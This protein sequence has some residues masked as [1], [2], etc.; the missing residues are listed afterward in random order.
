MK[1]N[2]KTIFKFP[3]ETQWI[4]GAA[5]VL[6]RTEFSLP[7]A[8]CSA[9]IWIVA[10]PHS[11]A[12][13]YWQKFRNDGN[14]G[15]W[16]LGGSFLKYRIFVNGSLIGVGPARPI[17]DGIPVIHCFDIDLQ[18]GKN[19]LG[20]FSRGEKK[21]FALY[22]EAE[23]KDGSKFQLCS[24]QEWKELNINQC[25]SPIC[26]ER[27]NIDQFF[28]GDAGPG[29]W[30]EH[31]DGTQYPFA[32]DKVGFD[33]QSWND[34]NTFGT[35]IGEAEKG[36]VQNYSIS[37]LSPVSIRKTGEQHYLI[38]FGKEYIGGLELTGPSLAASVELRLGEE[39]FSN[40]QVRYQLRTGNCYHEIWR[41]PDGKQSLSHFGLRSFRYLEIIDYPDE[42]TKNMIS[43]ISVTAP[44][45]K[46]ESSFSCENNDLKQV[47]DLCK[48][49]I[50]LTGMDVYN[51]C[52]TRERMAY[53]ADAY[54]CMLSH[55]AVESNPTVAK[56]SIEYLMNHHTWPCEWR[57]FMIPLF[58][59]YAMHTG[60]LEFID[61]Y[62]QEL[63]DQYSFA[64][65]IDKGLICK[66]PLKVIVDWPKSCQDN[67][68]FGD[69]CAVPNAFLYWNLSLLAE[70]AKFLGKTA[71]QAEFIALAEQVKTAFNHKLFN[72]KIGLYID[73]KNSEHS[74]FHA[75]MF[76]LR[77]GL[78]PEEAIEKC[79]DLIVKKGMV[80]SVYGA[81]FYL[82]TLFMY[83]RA[84]EAVSLMTADNDT[85]WLGMI[86]RGAT[87]TTESWNPE[88]K[89]NMSWAHPWGSAPVNVIA[90]QLLGLRPTAPG[91]SKYEFKPNPGSIK[92]AE[93]A[94]TTPRGK[95]K[96]SFKVDINGNIKKS[97][98]TEFN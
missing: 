96:T 33:D 5:N 65:L 56:R 81:Q 14:D 59:E 23:L 77:F 37:K 18:K 70:L 63:C 41:F 53:E 76:S 88:Q 51:D 84:D 82:D 6:S 83:N 15:D 47:W 71:E 46:D 8:I 35:V 31:I 64:H 38:D 87:I 50:A 20:V 24:N 75:N 26:W 19:V 40:D 10:D 79:L 93:L 48:N 73:S 36:K 49:S 4:A 21:G 42:L 45:N 74:S 90:K 78:V 60:D 92:S 17:N 55:F 22:L 57:Q 43:I 69:F 9:K 67:Y 1:K 58:Y 97:I 30:S 28:K 94:I 16:L 54:I 34:A 86:H 91:W 61:Q 29:E 72:D 27:Q 68:D 52:F 98:S 80:C 89:A 32:W 25:Y 13:E 2:K 62:F 39:L 66:F 85:S 44:F 12:K 95:I 3:P 7:D 11:Y